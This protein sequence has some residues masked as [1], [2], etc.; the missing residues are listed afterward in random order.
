MDHAIDFFAPGAPQAQGN[1]RVSR[2]GHVYESNNRLAAWRTTVATVASIARRKLN[3]ETIDAPVAVAVEFR[4][5]RPKRPKFDTP[6]V[7]PDLD[8]LQRAI[9]DAITAAG[10]ISDDARIVHWATTKRYADKTHQP[11]AHVRV[12]EIDETAEGPGVPRRP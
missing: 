1:H 7:A 11:G 9:G 2:T 5:P 10:V 12:W 6:A 3:A 8:K 4:M